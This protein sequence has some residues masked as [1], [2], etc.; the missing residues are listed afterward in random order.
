MYEV[1]S[2]A[3]CAALGIVLR[4][5]FVLLFHNWLAVKGQNP[6]NTSTQSNLAKRVPYLN[7]NKASATAVG[8]RKV[9]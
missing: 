7:D 8:S 3:Y 5:H 6:S 2:V 4:V 1:P 9:D